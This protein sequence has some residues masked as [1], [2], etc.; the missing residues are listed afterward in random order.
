M[1][2]DEG[3][4]RLRVPEIDPNNQMQVSVMPGTPSFFF[5]FLRGRELPLCKADVVL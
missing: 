4:S 2:D 1:K 5:F 3:D